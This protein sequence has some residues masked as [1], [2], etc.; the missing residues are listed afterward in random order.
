MGIPR[1]NFERLFYLV[2]AKVFAKRVLLLLHLLSS[3]QF[4]P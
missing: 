2:R 3:G 1:H 4:Y